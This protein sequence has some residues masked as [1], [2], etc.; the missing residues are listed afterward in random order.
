VVLLKEVREKPD[1]DLVE[2]CQ[3]GDASA[4]DELVRRYQDRVYNTVY[5]YLGNHE[6]ALDVA[7]EVFVRA[8][9]AID[10]FRGHAQVYT[11]LYSI[12]ANLARNRLRDH[13]RKGR[14]R[15]TSLDALE[16]AA[17]DAAQR[18]TA[19]TDTPRDLAQ[20]Q[21]L[22]QA[23]DHCLEAL[24]DLYRL[25]FVLRTWDGLSYED[26]AASCG[27]PKGTVK[28]RLNQARSRLAD[29][30]EERGVL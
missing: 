23:L 12:A 13:G 11:W 15:G 2:Q 20:R 18:A 29:C 21:E 27:C 10:T 1:V 28:S 19:A 5:R 30:L 25:A 26:I 16:E 14:N 24:P 7:Q 9:R 6:D 4:F 17:P 8:Y 3:A 22:E